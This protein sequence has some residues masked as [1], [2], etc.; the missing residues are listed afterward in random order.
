[1]RVLVV[2]AHP[3]P[4]SFVSH[5]RD[6]VLDELAA[7]GHEVRHHDLWAEEFDP[8]FTAD[9]RIT[10]LGNIDDKL[11]RHP[12]LKSHVEDLRWC[13]TLILTY[14][15]WW[16]GQPAILK[17]WFDRIFV[18]GVAWELPE[19]ANRIAPLLSNVR[20]LIVVTTYGSPRWMNAVQGEPGKRIALRSIRLMF[21]LRCR[22][23]H[24][25]LY[26]LDHASPRRRTAFES[27]V[28][29]RVRRLG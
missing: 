29:G 25:A 10:H 4:D 2:H 17:G 3:S 26:G 7:A 11:E 22:A 20:R 15:T 18:S 16:G 21:T 5:L 24:L 12:V 13:D 19:G 9:E 23:S 14:P 28:R 1:M 6:V 8:V 27:R